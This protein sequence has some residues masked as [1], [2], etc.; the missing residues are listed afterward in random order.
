[1]RSNVPGIQLIDVVATGTSFVTCGATGQR[2]RQA[3]VKVRRIRTNKRLQ[4]AVP[5][6][7][8]AKCGQLGLGQRCQR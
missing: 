1:M 5:L 7:C 3:I 8:C 6:E 4:N 2:K